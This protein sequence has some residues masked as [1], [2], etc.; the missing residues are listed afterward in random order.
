[1]EDLQQL[2]QQLRQPIERMINSIAVALKLEVAVFDNEA[3]LVCCTP[4]YLK[5][6][7]RA[8]HAPSIQE[9]LHYGSIVV[10][11]PGQM[12]S[13]IGC[14][15]RDN[16][17]STMELLACIKAD[18]AV[19]GVVSITSFTKE[20]FNRISGNTDM[21]METISEIALMLGNFISSKTRRVTSVHT[22]DLIRTV[23]EMST[24]PM[25]LTD[26]NGVIVQYNHI[27][28]TSLRFCQLSASSLWH[29]VPEE[30]AQKALRGVEFREKEFVRDGYHARF[31]SLPVLQDGQT[32]GV[33]VRLTDDHYGDESESFSMDHIIGSTP[34]TR[35]LHQLIRKVANS[36]SP[37]LIT[38]ETGTGKELVARA[39]HEQSERRRYPFV[40]VNCS[41][42]P[43]T[44]FESE[45]FGYSEGSFTGAKKG[46]KAGKIEMAQGGTLFLDEL[47][48]MPMSMQPKLL[49]VLQEYEL[50]RVGSTEKIPL[51]IRVIAA[52]NCNLEEMMRQGKFRKDLYYRIGVVNLELPPLRERQGDIMPIAMNYLKKLKLSFATPVE[53][54]SREAEEFFLRCPWPGN[55]RE[56]QN[57]VEYVANLCEHREVTPRD[58]PP[59]LLAQR[60]A[61]PT[62][63]A[64]ATAASGRGRDEEAQIQKLL[65]QYGETLD[66]KKRIAD[67]LHVSLRTLYRKL[68]KYGMK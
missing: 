37:I 68:E 19:A 67:E 34:Q 33:V 62:S 24:H 26:A 61:R 43:D 11:T 38:G 16:C 54:F 27:A 30:M 22:D 29:I 60:S 53:C 66:G 51:N 36:S 65:D 63:A 42:I 3:H 40:A 18:G 14:R 5:K 49:R 32:M 48:E 47:G 55:V 44:L 52:T 45:L 31:S 59:Q 25:L 13:C 41:G 56:L 4:V 58:L 39:I 7:G 35:T 8:V 10:N 46:G 9:V 28:K 64:R 12:P 50:E 15:F 23:M 1:M 20:G 57:A 6:K 21:Y 2:Q 17:P